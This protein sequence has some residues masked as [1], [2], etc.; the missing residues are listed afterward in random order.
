MLM[1]LTTGPISIALKKIKDATVAQT[2]TNK[3]N[4]IPAMFPSKF[5]FLLLARVSN[6]ALS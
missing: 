5:K 1:T 6:S 4:T 3:P 2:P